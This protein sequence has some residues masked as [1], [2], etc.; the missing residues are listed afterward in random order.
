MNDQTDPKDMPRN[1]RFDSDSKQDYVRRGFDAIAPRY[2]FMNDLMTGGL[3]RRWKRETVRRLHLQPGM[4]VLD[5][6]TGTGDLASRA[7]SAIHPDGMV[8]ALDFSWQMMAAGRQR[9]LHHA[10]LSWISGDASR[11]PFLENSFHG[12]MVGFGLRNVN[13]IETVL[14]EVIR[15]LKPGARFVSLDT[16]Q[17]EWQAIMPFFRFYMNRIVPWLGRFFAGS[18]DMY[19]YL[20]TSAE[21]FETPQQLEAL[22]QQCGFVQTGYV[23]R[24]R[25]LGGAGLVWGQKPGDLS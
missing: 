20:S 9:A 16:A 22:F 5:L 7:F 11:L 17:A 12:A 2:D 8:A 18:R 10:N 21:A 23:Y 13:S 25:I 6:C 1:P 3:H 24:P 19:A 14:R 15:V 4:R